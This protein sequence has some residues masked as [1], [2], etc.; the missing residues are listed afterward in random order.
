MNR[1][2][3]SLALALVSTIAI[4]GCVVNTK[5]QYTE[6]CEHFSKDNQWGKNTREDINIL[7]E[8]TS[9]KS[10]FYDLKPTKTFSGIQSAQL[11]GSTLTLKMV[12]NGLFEQF[13]APIID[14]IREVQYEA[15]P[16]TG[17]FTPVG[18]IVWLFNQKL[19]NDYTFGCTERRFLRS[20]PDETKKVQTGKSEW[21]DIQKDHKIL[22]TGFD[23]DYEFRVNA[24]NSTKV[25]DLNTA[26]LNTPLSKNIT[27]KV[28]CLDCDLS[29]IDEKTLYPNVKNEVVLTHDFRATK[30]ALSESKRIREEETQKAKFEQEKRDREIAKQA[31]IQK[32]SS[33]LSPANSINSD[34]SS[35]SHLEEIKAKCKDL[36]FKPQ[37][38][39]FG[40]CVLELTK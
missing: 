5:D 33:V 39:K 2:K 26:I 4:D 17:T 16:L 11:N 30:L 35:I 28:T 19:M 15:H 3:I 10:D 1:K 8:A 34:E 25:I 14:V 29:D 18:S 22:I 31:Q 32:T 36:G 21:K 20:E 37:S 27:F 24:D 23:K 12:N 6:S 7:K 40:K 9:K 38:D 13:S